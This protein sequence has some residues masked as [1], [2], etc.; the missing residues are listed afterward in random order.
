[1][2]K[3]MLVIA[4]GVWTVVV[5]QLG[6]PSSWKMLL[7]VATGVAIAAVGFLLRGE[8]IGR[9]PKNTKDARVSGSSYVESSLPTGRQASVRTD[10][11][12]QKDGIN[13]LN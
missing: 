3:E 12:D 4:L 9:R 11:Y 6:I 10:L 1:M 13:S 8:A 2:S 7:F 5:T